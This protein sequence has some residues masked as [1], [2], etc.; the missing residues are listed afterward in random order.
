MTA[1][2]IVRS[3]AQRAALYTLWDAPVPVGAVLL[4]QPDEQVV[5]LADGQVRNVLSEGR[6]EL[7]PARLPFLADRVDTARGVLRVQLC[8][9]TVHRPVTLSWEGVLG[10]IEE[11]RPRV[12]V[13]P[14]VRVRLSLSV[15]E[16]L[17][18][19]QLVGAL[20]DAASPDALV[21]EW[22]RRVEAWVKHWAHTI[23]TQEG[24]VVHLGPEPGARL[25]ERL[26]A[27][28]SAATP[29]MGLS[30]H[31]VDTLEV[32]V[33][34]EGAARLR[35]LGATVP[36]AAEWVAPA[37][38]APGAVAVE[39]L[40]FVAT[41]ALQSRCRTPGAE[42]SALLHDTGVPLVVADAG[43][44]PWWRGAQP[45]VW[46]L[47]QATRPSLGV[48][49]QEMRLFA[50]EA[51]ALAAYAEARA[52]LG[53]A[54]SGLQARDARG[55]APRLAP[56]SAKA[57]AFV[58]GADEVAWLSVD[59]VSDALALAAMTP[60]L[61]AFTLGA[62]GGLGIRSSGKPL[63]VA[64]RRHEGAVDGVVLADLGD[65]APEALAG[66]VAGR[67]E[68]RST[69]ATSIDLPSGVALVFWGAVAGSALAGGVAAEAGIAAVTRGLAGRDV[70]ALA[71]AFDLFAGGSLAYAM[72]LRPG[73]YRVELFR[74][75]EGAGRCVVLTHG[76]SGPW[77]PGQ[78]GAASVAG[79][80]SLDDPEVLPGTSHPRVSDFGRL[81][82]RLRRGERAVVLAQEGLDEDAADTVQL[83]WLGAIG[84]DPD[85]AD[86][87]VPWMR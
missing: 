5:V 74:A 19:A 60:E 73:R 86:G 21:A 31:A 85:L 57:E 47:R 78:R 51:E 39:G 82:Q 65:A 42:A 9:V 22:T 83:A 87:L 53:R 34:A 50:T 30:L 10:D 27:A 67:W 55:D 38:P 32:L 48:A 58:Q 81:L 45:T 23:L 80:V 76:E 72:R 66:L 84:D 49:P 6:F 75:A 13:S 18:V 16:V 44:A 8:F 29:A 25:R 70:G 28:L 37:V 33:T 14:R 17:A 54:V 36:A 15:Q 24:V 2:P 41:G 63:Q 64:L 12:R 69:D 40:P 35:A 7:D 52:A 26:H 11:H 56:G 43:V 77:R 4:C 68:A 62:G 71:T 1:P 20:G 59:Q 79:P 46:A 3:V 61:H